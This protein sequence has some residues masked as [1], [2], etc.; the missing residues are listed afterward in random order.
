MEIP[1]DVLRKILDD[2]AIAR[3]F[4][5]DV[6]AREALAIRFSNDSDVVTR[7]ETIEGRDGTT[8]VI[9]YDDNMNVVLIEL[10]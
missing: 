9:D 1:N 7:T 5:D 4:E 6:P 10:V 3:E 2:L 8:I